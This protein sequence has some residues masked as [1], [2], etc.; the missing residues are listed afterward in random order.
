MPDAKS[1]IP[2]F[3]T[4]EK[5]L[6]ILKQIFQLQQNKI[7]EALNKLKEEGLEINFHDPKVNQV[8]QNIK[9]EEV[10]ERVLKEN[11]LDDFDD[12]AE[13]ILHYAIQKFSQEDHQFS[14]SYMNL[15][16]GH[17]KAFE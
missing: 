6:D 11:N 12:P 4:K 13:K 5:T 7:K 1:E 17:Q 2:E 9:M 16:M 8:L 10:K 15:E 3:L 14:Q